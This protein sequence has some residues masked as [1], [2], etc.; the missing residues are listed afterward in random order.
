MK[1]VELKNVSFSYN[2][3][4]KVLDNVSFSANYGEITLVAGHSGE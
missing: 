3:K 4:E 1:A 2:G